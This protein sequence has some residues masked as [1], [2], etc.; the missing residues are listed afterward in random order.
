MDTFAAYSFNLNQFPGSNEFTALYDEYRIE[1]LR[2]ELQPETG[3]SSGSPCWSVIDYDDD[4]TP[5]STGDIVQYATLMKS[6]PG[7]S[8]Q[9][10]FKPKVETSVYQSTTATGYAPRANVWID[11]GNPTVPHYGIKLAFPYVAGVN[12]QHKVTVTARI[13]CRNTR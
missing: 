10:Q 3:G 6:A 5:T 9:R 7:Q 2:F 4:T 8:F 1:Y 11:L 13:Q 12:T